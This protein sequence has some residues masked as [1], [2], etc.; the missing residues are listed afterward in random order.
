V[1]EAFLGEGRGRAERDG[2]DVGRDGLYPVEARGFL[3]ELSFRLLEALGIG[4]SHDTHSPLSRHDMSSTHRASGTNRIV[5]K[6]ERLTR[7]SRWLHKVDHYTSQPWATLL[8]GAILVAVVVLGASLGFPTPW[9]TAFEVGGSCIT[10]MMVVI[11]QHTQGREQTATQRKLDELLRALPQAQSTLMMLE[12]ESDETIQAVE[13][14]QR[15]T[16][17]N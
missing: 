8:L 5:P 13:D 6:T 11:I 17:N 4:Q 16:K 10:L 14:I 15:V 7:S 9:T 2:P 3:L 1:G 12:E